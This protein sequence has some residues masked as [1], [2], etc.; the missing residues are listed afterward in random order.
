MSDISK[1]DLKY[2]AEN[3]DRIVSYIP[4]GYFARIQAE[5]LAAR[6][7]KKEEE[8]YEKKKNDEEKND[9]DEENKGWESEEDE[10][11]DWGGYP[12]EGTPMIFH[13]SHF[14]YDKDGNLVPRVGP[15]TLALY[16]DEETG[17]YVDE[18]VAKV[19]PQEV[20][21][22]EAKQQKAKEQTK[23]PYSKPA[24]QRKPRT[25]LSLLKPIPAFPG[26]KNPDLRNEDWGLPLDQVDIKIMR[27]KE[28]GEW[29][30]CQ[31]MLALKDRKKAWKKASRRLKEGRDV[32]MTEVVQEPDQLE[33]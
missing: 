24:T 6:K 1:E 3:A 33:V 11:E 21:E 15:K 28:R 16:Y 9:E 23:Q 26:Y 20:E 13:L 10:H 22:Q 32:V 30:R 12:N 25:N 14:I 2:L 5:A 29:H 31:H 17:D 27:Y 8:E 7:L 4:L 18:V 19:E